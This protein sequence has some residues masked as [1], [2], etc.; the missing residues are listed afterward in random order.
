LNTAEPFV[1]QMRAFTRRQLAVF[2]MSCADRMSPAF[3]AFAQHTPASTYVK[4]MA[5]AWQVVGAR[6][7]VTARSLAV[8]MSAA[9]EADETD[10]YL[11]DYWAMR[12][13]N[14]LRYAVEAVFEN[15][16]E[17]AQWSSISARELLASFAYDVPNNLPELEVSEQVAV[18]NWL[19]ATGAGLEI[20]DAIKRA[21]KSQVKALLTDVVRRFAVSNGWESPPLGDAT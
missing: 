9:P 13:L 18:V 15:A 2:C 6:D 3:V 12:A 17:R 20:D 11:P 16:L 7:K 10:S 4:W 5:Q 14:P 1:E 21:E 8:E 19:A